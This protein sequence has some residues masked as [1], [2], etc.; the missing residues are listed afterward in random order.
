M[1]A[2]LILV[3][4]SAAPCSAQPVRDA[5]WM[6]GERLLRLMTYGSLPGPRSAE[7]D[8]DYERARLYIDGVHDTSE[9]TS[10]CYSERSRPGREALQSD[11]AYWLRKMEPS[12]LNRNAADLVVDIW[13]RR[14]PCAQRRT[15]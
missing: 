15:R 10:W 14:W 7:Q 1:R 8:L 4:L 12:Q 9:G 6:T 11:V 2:A 13:R 5:P 3:V